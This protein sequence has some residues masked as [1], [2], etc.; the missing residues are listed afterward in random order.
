M[1]RS[2]RGRQPPLRLVRPLGVESL[3]VPHQNHHKD[4][5]DHP[6]PQPVPVDLSV[7]D[8]YT[9]E[10]CMTELD[11]TIARN[12]FRFDGGKLNGDSAGRE[13]TRTSGIDKIDG[14]ALVCDYAFDPCGYSMNGMNLDRYSTIH[15]T[16]EDGFSYASFE[17]VGS[18]RDGNVLEVLKRVV[19]IF[20]P[21]KMS[22]STTAGP[23]ASR[24][25]ASRA[26]LGYALLVDPSTRHAFMSTLFDLPVALFDQPVFP[27]PIDRFIR[28][29]RL[30]SCTSI[31]A[32]TFSA[33]MSSPSSSST[34]V[35]LF[36]HSPTP[37]LELTVLLIEL[38]NRSMS[39][40]LRRKPTPLAFS[41]SS[42]HIQTAPSTSQAGTSRHCLPIGSTSFLDLWMCTSTPHLVA[43]PF[44]KTRSFHRPY[45]SMTESY[46]T[47]ASSEGR[48]LSC[49][50]MSSRTTSTKVA[51]QNATS[52]VKK[53]DASAKAKG[54][55]TPLTKQTDKQGD[56]TLN[57]EEV[58]VVPPPLRSLV[59]N[60]GRSIIT[61]YL[62][63]VLH[64]EDT[65][66][67][68]TDLKEQ[69]D[70]IRYPGHFSVPMLDQN[71]SGS[72][73]SI[74]ELEKD[75]RRLYEENKMLHNEKFDLRQ[76]LAQKALDR[77]VTRCKVDVK[78]EFVTS[79]SRGRQHLFFL[80]KCFFA[81]VEF[82]KIDLDKTE[83]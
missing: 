55:T 31:E 62:M 83:K 35:P 78:N 32:N 25:S 28:T 34:Y 36:T 69:S 61:S 23:G 30:D 56:K 48:S 81:T 54:H 45:L 42:T 14:N 43:I 10:I 70:Y 19:G 20:G 58:E 16:P 27:C 5:W 72:D 24:W 39:L 33:R 59:Y 51:T 12:F 17:C 37:S 29:I 77:E 80:V 11:P 47:S 63:K 1:H 76:K 15:V 22:V 46:S 79:A 7:D 21:G 75:N 49:P 71:M 3:R 9:V 65:N 74:Q 26:K 68:G 4:V 18:S 38:F 60:S 66:R 41:I 13:M 64:L 73:R 57:E 82:Y 50:K 44:S 67:W 8:S 53:S 6:A 52:L 40:N 2:L